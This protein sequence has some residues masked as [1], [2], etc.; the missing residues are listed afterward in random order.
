MCSRYGKLAVPG[1]LTPTEIITAYEAGAQVV[2]I[3]P[4]RAFGPD[5]I[6]DLK[7]PLNH[8]NIIAVG[9]ITIENTADYLLAGAIGVGVGSELVNLK[10]NRNRSF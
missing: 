6:K 3:F 9:G 7:G 8:I 1:V 5:Y 10:L 4:A 2:K